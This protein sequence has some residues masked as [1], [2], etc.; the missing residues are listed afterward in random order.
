MHQLER[1]GGLNVFRVFHRKLDASAPWRFPEK[2]DFTVLSEA[3]V[4][5]EC[6]DSEM[7][8]SAGSVREAFARGGVCIGAR[9]AGEL[10]GYVWFA[11]DTAPHLQGVWVQVP[12]R[13]IYRYKA[14]VRP[15]HRGKGIAPALYRFADRVFQGRG[16]EEVVNCIATHNF[17]SIAA[18]RRSGAHTL[19][20]LGYWQMGG[21]FLSFHSPQVRRFGLRFYLAATRPMAER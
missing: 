13:A 20:Y 21:R 17:A 18:S 5:A 3:Q 12:P 11:F 14:F 10:A 9:A 1:R 4:L 2:Y 16:R 15:S 8:L 7:D 19:G 6:S